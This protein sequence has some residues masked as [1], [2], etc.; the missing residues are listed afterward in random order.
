MAP[1]CS[2]DSELED[3]RRHRRGRA[4]CSLCI[5]QIACWA[6]NS[7]SKVQRGP[8]DV[9]CCLAQT[10]SV[11]LRMRGQKDRYKPVHETTDGWMAERPTTGQR[12]LRL[13][14]GKW[15]LV[16]PASRRTT[17]VSKP[18]VRAHHLS[19]HL[20]MLIPAEMQHCHCAA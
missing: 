18:L 20:S 10:W 15:V 9:S 2:G 8:I 12:A 19:H 14:K 7:K 6:L 13:N 3:D 11:Q 17:T 1:A 5:L 4:Q 16:P